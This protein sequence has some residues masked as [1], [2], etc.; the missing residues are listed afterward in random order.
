MDQELIQNTRA[1]QQKYITPIPVVMGLVKKQN[2]V[3]VVKNNSK[4]KHWQ[5]VTGFINTKESAEDAIIREVKEETNLKIKI[6][7]FIGTFPY[8]K[9]K[10][11]L[12]IA[13]KLVYVSGILKPQDDIV[14]VKWVDANKTVKFKKGSVSKW[15]YERFRK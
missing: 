4:L 13:F 5:L 9:D 1:N 12:I 2:Q 10:I 11:I 8:L 7:S 14:E 15:V 3:L 6:N